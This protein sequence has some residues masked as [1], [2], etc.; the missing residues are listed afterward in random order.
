MHRSA[1][2]AEAVAAVVL[3]VD[4]VVVVANIH[5]DVD[6]DVGLAVNGLVHDRTASL[7]GSTTRR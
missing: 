4:S 1:V 5:R 2:R 3:V 6:A 7:D